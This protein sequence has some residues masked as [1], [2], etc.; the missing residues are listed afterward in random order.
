MQA[1]KSVGELIDENPKQAALVV[2]NWL[3]NA[4]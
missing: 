2:R 1:L 4:A 3:N